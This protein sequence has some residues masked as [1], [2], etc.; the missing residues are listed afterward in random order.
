[1]HKRLM[2]I[3]LLLAFALAPVSQAQCKYECRTGVDGEGEQ[4]AHCVQYLFGMH[5][6]NSCEEIL[7]CYGFFG[8]GYTCYPDCAGER[9]Y[10]V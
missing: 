1:M 3:V 10:L 2:V 5:D 6:L 7:R 4:F 8:G 9:C